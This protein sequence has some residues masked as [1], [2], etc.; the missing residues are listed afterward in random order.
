MPDFDDT[1]AYLTTEQVAAR[2]G[3]QPATVKGWRSRSRRNIKHQGPPWYSVPH[4]GQPYG[5]AIIRYR[6]ADVLA[7]EQ[8]NGITP[9]D[10]TDSNHG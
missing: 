4:F 3:I 8:A 6:L 5:A 2:Y 10:R 7:W 9:I 1:A